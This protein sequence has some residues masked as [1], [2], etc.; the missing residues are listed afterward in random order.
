MKSKWMSG[1]ALAAMLLAG[2]STM[3]SD[4]GKGAAEVNLAE[5][6]VQLTQISGV[7]SAARFVSGGISVKYRV[8]VA[9]RSGE[10][11]TLKRIDLQSMG[12]GGYDL[13]P[14]SIST[15]L[16]VQ[17]DHYESTEFWTAANIDDPSMNGANG[18]V[19]VRAVAHFDSP[20]GQFQTVT[21]QQVN[22]PTRGGGAQ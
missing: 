18:P 3:Q 1:A 15:K 8:V 20:V 9:N 11:I 4:S 7:P 2:C 10:P 22:D 17:P 5:P 19:S 21:V 13:R 16:L 14:T 6:D 12:Y